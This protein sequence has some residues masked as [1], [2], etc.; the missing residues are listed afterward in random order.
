MLTSPTSYLNCKVIFLTLSSNKSSLHCV[1]WGP[2]GLSRTWPWAHQNHGR[3]PSFADVCTDCF[4]FCN[5]PELFPSDTHPFTK[6]MLN[7]NDLQTVTAQKDEERDNHLQWAVRANKQINTALFSVDRGAENRTHTGIPR[8]LTRMTVLVYGHGHVSFSQSSPG[9]G[10]RACW[11][12]AELRWRYRWAMHRWLSMS[13]VR[14][15]L[16]ERCISSIANLD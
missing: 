2:Q 16:I 7:K 10:E 15:P 14:R 5:I 4:I 13:Y 6:L 11:T 12:A 1:L 9:A 8:K 3:L